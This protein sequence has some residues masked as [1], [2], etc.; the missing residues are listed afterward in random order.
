MIKHKQ[1]KRK[2]FKLSQNK[3][4]LLNQLFYVLLIFFFL[5][6][7]NFFLQTNS[8][9]THES[10]S[11]VDIIDDGEIGI[12]T[13]STN[14]AS[15]TEDIEADS[16]DNIEDGSSTPS[17]SL[18]NSTLSDSDEFLN[19]TTPTSIVSEILN[20]S[21]ANLFK[22]W[23]DV[24]SNELFE[25]NINFSG[26]KLL[27][28]TYNVHLRKDA[29]FA[30]INFTEMIVNISN[31]ISKVLYDKTLVVKNLSSLVEKA[32]NE[33]SNN[34]DRVVHSTK[35]V[36]YDSK[37]PKTFCDTLEMYQNQTYSKLIAKAPHHK[38][39]TAPPT[40]TTTTTTPKAKDQRKNKRSL[41]DVDFLYDLN[42]KANNLDG[43]KF[44]IVDSDA[45]FIQNEVTKMVDYN[46]EEDEIVQDRNKRN[47]NSVEVS[48]HKNVQTKA[49]NKPQLTSKKAVKPS[50]RPQQ[51]SSATTPSTTTT[52]LPGSEDYYDD[53][54]E[55]ESISEG[56]YEDSL[57]K[58][59]WDVPCIN[60]SYDEN[61]KSVKAI[62]RNKSTVQVPVNVFKQD[63]AINMTAYWTEEL[64][65]QFKKNYDT[66]NEV[67]WQ[68]FC[69]S[70][71]LFRRFPAAY[72]TVTKNDFFDCRLQSWYIMAAASPKD[73]IIL[74]DTSGSMT[75][76]RL[77]IGK[78]LIEFIMDTFTDNDFFNILTFSNSVQYLFHDEPD[79][80]DTFIQA[81]KENKRKF[82]ER[83]D[84]F[85]NTSQQ[86]RLTKPLEKVFSLFENSTLTRSRC[87][88]VIMIITDGHAD[89]VDPVFAKYNSDKRIRV[90]SFK[91]GRDMTDPSEIK[92]LACDN[93]GEY[94]HVVTLT[95]INEHIYEYI[96]VLSRPM[97]L[98]GLKETTWSNVFIGYLDKEL[99]IAVA[100]P[101]FRD[102]SYNY[103]EFE[104]VK[105]KN[106][107]LGFKIENFESMVK[108]NKNYHEYYFANDT[109]QY[110]I[111]NAEK[112]IRKQQV[113]LG[114]VGVDVPVLRLISKVS[115]KYQMGVG[116]YIIMLDNNGFIVFHPSIKKE[117]TTSDFNFKGSSHSIDLD[118]FEIPI[119]NDAEFEELEHEMI[120]QKTSKKTLDNWKR[121]GLRVIRRRTEYV[122]TP[123]SKTPFSVAI[124]SP[125]SFGRYYIDL[126]SEKEADY[127]KKLREFKEKEIKFE[128]LIQ[129][130]NCSYTYTR[131]TERLTNPKQL[132]DYCIRY[133]FMDRDQV[134]A[135][136]SDLVLHNL[137][138][139]KYNFSVFSQFRNLVKSSF[140]GTYSGITFYLPVTFYRNKP[141]PTNNSTPTQTTSSTTVV[142]NVSAKPTIESVLLNN[143]T[144]SNTTVL[145]LTTSLFTNSPT[146]SFY[147]D[148]SANSD[149]EAY[150]ASLNLF[151]TESNK[152]T[153]S[154]EKQYYTRSIEF[155][156]YLRTEI[157]TAEPIVIYFLN[158]TTK[159][160]VDD[161]ISAAM[162]IWL[163]KVPAAVAGVVYDSEKLKELLFDSPPSCDNETCFNVCNRK[164][165]LGVT[166]Y[167]VDE[168]GIV[169]LSNSEQTTMIGQPLYKINPWLM[170]RLEIDGLYDLIVH[171][172]K[173]QDCSKPPMKF[174][175]ASSLFNIIGYGLKTVAYLLNQIFGL[176]CFGLYHMIVYLFGGNSLV[177]VF[178]SEKSSLYSMASAQMAQSQFQTNPKVEINQNEWRIRN[179]HCFYFGIYSFNITKWKTMD[180][181]ELKTWCN[182][183]S[184]QTRNYLA[185]YLKN[186]N[187]IML[188]VE[189]ETE[190]SKCGSIDNLIKNRPPSWESKLPKSQNNPKNETKNKYSINRYR[191]DPEYCHNYYPNESQIFFCKSFSSSINSG[192]L[193]DIL[194]KHTI[195]S[196]LFYFIILRIFNKFF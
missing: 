151:S 25:L 70:Q 123:V 158:E 63:I 15:N 74:L 43:L 152:H 100:R 98:S 75:G 175:S 160:A 103:S 86:S 189:D 108:K 79:Y 141:A 179:S 14:D 2:L 161:T 5:N 30:W 185:G 48:H 97:A 140:Y 16:I 136:K 76:L 94:Y 87:N 170:L 29:N 110:L 142:T 129:L 168:H 105:Y 187:L 137:Y 3:F 157:K 37:S 92:K 114:V 101:A 146:T 148:S 155:S 190:V 167:L 162:P 32:F 80:M 174:N 166:C 176:G 90:F 27:N 194:T 50:K 128:S 89:D 144:D 1:A 164:E 111:E 77:E 192:I 84:T 127:E 17:S 39:T 47:Q 124:A 53:D 58:D 191:K 150:N 156:D 49:P 186:S 35:H 33:Y 52:T 60:R 42:S 81:G 138:Y 34:T 45:D 57:E 36:Y 181:G 55:Q 38:T 104:I 22:S 12:D 93:N 66:D 116:I 135:I 165:S 10:D 188:V 99:K 26:Y 7:N 62:N 109:E 82:K 145:T 40:T 120:D 117:I 28:E 154:F 143:A 19:A 31:T 130:Y 172:N 11:E 95:D 119:N 85:K 149:L 183:S 9:E 13:N 180:S 193:F 118:K 20:K 91:I 46:Q 54:G 132:S 78:K 21:N 56:D 96:P 113:L 69:S 121:E 122:Y 169:V 125:S 59:F 4:K 139:N 106:L 182:S 71:G 173:L 72:W 112:E 184:N 88:K 131:L 195:F 61:F 18:E 41:V 64:D 44:K 73:V 67:F 171:G 126:P 51:T 8:E 163:D 153:Y 178:S 107:T 65:E 83:L 147:T 115:P 23:L 6:S 159:D 196:C 177:K 68:Y 24:K 133:L 102:T 134:L